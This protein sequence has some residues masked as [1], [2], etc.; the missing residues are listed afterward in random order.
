MEI[1]P[2]ENLKNFPIP[3]PIYEKV[4]I[5]DAISRDGENFTITV[6]LDKDLV[7]QLVKY[8]LDKNDTELQ[9][10]TGDMARFGIG[11]YEDWY[12]KN[13]TPFCLIHKDTNKL[14]ALV[15]FGPKPAHEG[16]KC[17]ASAWRSYIP[18]RGK[19]VMKDFTKYAIYFYIKSVPNTN[20][21][22]EIKNNNQASID[23]AKKLGFVVDEILSDNISTVLGK[24]VVPYNNG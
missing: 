11:S 18:F 21:W 13:R 16:C 9:K 17:H 23:L 10:N 5:A 24:K 20:L 14:A 3:L 6:G 1:I 7:Y 2:K 22:A 19:G 15:W 8:S 12:K 4:E